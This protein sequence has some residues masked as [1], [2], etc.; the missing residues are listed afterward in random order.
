MRATSVTARINLCQCCREI[1]QPAPRV[2]W[3]L[4]EEALIPLP[5]HPNPGLQGSTLDKGQN[6][7]WGQ[8]TMSRM[9]SERI[10]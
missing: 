9:L 2:G 5:T 4:A 7:A 1:L 10:E 6:G 3:T 8:F